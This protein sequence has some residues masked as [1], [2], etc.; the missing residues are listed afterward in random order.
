MKLVIEITEETITMYLVK[1]DGQK[2]VMLINQTWMHALQGIDELTGTPS[3]AIGV[4]RLAVVPSIHLAPNP[5][6][7]AEWE[8]LENEETKE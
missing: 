3:A 1:P 5:E 4:S 2:W 6:L 7:K 8:K